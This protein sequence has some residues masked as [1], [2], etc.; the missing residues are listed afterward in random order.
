M[1]LNKVILAVC[2]TAF[3]MNTPGAAFGKV[4][5]RQ[6]SRTHFWFAAVHV[7]PV[8]GLVPHTPNIVFATGLPAV[9]KLPIVARFSQNHLPALEYQ[10]ASS[11]V[12]RNETVRPSIRAV[13]LRKAS[14]RADGL[15][16]DN[17]ACRGLS[18][19]LGASDS[20]VCR[21]ADLVRWSP[22]V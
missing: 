15:L 1:N 11:N 20:A 8:L 7:E 9:K 2:F 21:S 14:P 3:G 5:M 10:R 6:L 22:L 18:D 12:L 19:S 4:Q 16:S 13:P 17:V